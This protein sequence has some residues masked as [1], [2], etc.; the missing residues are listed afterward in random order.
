LSK[1]KIAVIGRGTAGSLGLVHFAKHLPECEIDWYFDPKTPPQAVGE[2]STLVLPKNLFESMAFTYQ[3]LRKIKGTMKT[4]IYKE[5]WGPD[6][7]PFFH[8]FPPPQSGIHFNAIELQN[9]ILEHAKT[10]LN[11]RVT[12]IPEAVDYENVDADF[13]FNATGAPKQLEKFYSSKYIPVNAAYVTQCYWDVPRFDYTLTIAGKYGWIFGIPLQNRCSIGY[14][15]NSGINTEEEVA[16]DVKEIFEKYNLVP[17]KDT[18][19]LKFNNYFRKENYENNGRLVHSGNSSF[20]L[21]PLEATSI[22]LMDKIQRS[23]W[24]LWTGEKRIEEAHFKYLNEINQIEFVIM[25]HYAA[26]SRFKTD[27]WEFAQ[28]R[29]IKKLESMGSDSEAQRIYQ[30]T[31]GYKTM[32][33]GE[34]VMGDVKEFGSWWTGSFIQNIHGLG[35]SDTMARIFEGRANKS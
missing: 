26:G 13:V 6:S 15:Y 12:M 3:D 23:A 10:L 19:S 27:F 30:L 8:D 29:G 14:M 5:N 31:K 2:G 16:E 4:G 35:L 7:E 9:Y 32:Y 11:K 33:E 22:G 21:E 1:K 20:F 24:D 25:M 28:E 17:S 34:K 18:N